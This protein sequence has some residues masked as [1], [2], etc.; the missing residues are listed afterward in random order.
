M[1]ISAKVTEAEKQKSKRD[2]DYKTD[3]SHEEDAG[4]GRA[5]KSVMRLTGAA[6]A[7]F[8]LGCSSSANIAA[9]FPSA[10]SPLMLLCETRKRSGSD[11]GVR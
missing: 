7:S 3:Y 1:E 10:L 8:E 6:L 11:G 4:G 5:K 9:S 2:I